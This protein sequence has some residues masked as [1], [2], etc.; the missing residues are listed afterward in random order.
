MSKE[1]KI[2][3]NIY[4]ENI[5]VSGLTES[6]A[7][8]KLNNSLYN[9]DSIELFYGD[10]KYNLS[11]NEINFKFKVEDAVNTAINIGRDSD[12]FNNI[13]TKFNLSTGKIIKLNVD[14]DYNKAK[15]NEYINNLSKEID[16][17]PVD[18]TITVENNNFNISKEVYGVNLK[19]EVLLS[20]I[21][22]NIKNKKFG[23]IN[24]YT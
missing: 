7:I 16:I 2:Y 5:D 15:L 20:E 1:S 21:D 10:K 13:K 6:D 17:T 23:N 3:K 9:K 14:T 4:I 11:L 22:K 19:K 12:F 24:I 8:K 18:A